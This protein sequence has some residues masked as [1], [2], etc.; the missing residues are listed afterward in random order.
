V[1][2][3]WA[4]T[5]HIHDRIGCRCLFATHYHELIDLASD[6]PGICNLT[7][8]VAEQDDDVTFLH[9]IIPGAATKS[10]GIHV[11]RLAGVPAGVIS[12]AREVLSTLEQLNVSLT[13]R[14]RPAAR[15]H[16]APGGTGPVQ[17]TLFA[18][19][20]HSATLQRLIAANLDDLS[21]RQ[22]Q[23]L[24]FALQAAARTE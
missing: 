4:I 14:E 22:A 1:S 15:T 2:L 16:S 8:S 21:P 5:E 23:E 10:Y 9:R 7:V 3:A 11:A 13:E 18:P 24:L 6:R 12:R 20:Q 19:F 17:L